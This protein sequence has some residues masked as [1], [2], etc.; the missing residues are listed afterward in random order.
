MAAWLRS[1]TDQL[2]PAIALLASRRSRR[3]S[4]AEVLT[5]FGYRLVFADGPHDVLPSELASI[6]TDLWLL[7]AAEDCDAIDWLLEQSD[8]PVLIGVNDTPGI[9]SEDYPRWQRQLYHKLLPLLGRPP[10]GVTP[11][12][13]P[14]RAPGAVGCVWVLAAS[15][16]GPSAVKA[17]LDR[18]PATLPVAFVYAQHIDAAFEAKLPQIIG[19]HNE[20]RV[21]NCVAGA[22]LAPGEVMVAPIERSMRFGP[23]GQIRLGDAPWPG[24]YQPAIESVIDEVMRSFAPACGAIMFSGMGE[25]GVAACGRMRQY[26]MQV[27]TQTA[28]SATCAVMPQAVQDAGHSSRQGSPEQLAGALRDWLEQEWAVAL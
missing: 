26:G 6:E 19:R 20:W 28:E 4:L 27:W 5:D 23:D 14:A 13:A 17:F 12:F 22:R 25:D 9:D 7:D 8:V 11:S 2:A 3:D 16:G 24:P 18:L 15:L 10:T 21:V 1:V